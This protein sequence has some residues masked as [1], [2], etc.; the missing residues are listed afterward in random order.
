MA[1]REKEL[2]KSSANPFLRANFAPVSEENVI[3]NLAVSG[4]IPPEL[5]GR[6]L[7]IGPNPTS[8]PNPKNHHWFLGSGM[9]HGLRLNQGRAEW[10]RNNY[11][12]SGNVAQDL[13][14]KPLPKI[15]KRRGGSVNT[16]V[17][18][19]AGELYALVEAG[20]LPIRLDRDLQSVAN[21][22]FSG[23]LK[24][25]FS[26]H[27]RRDP[28]TG[29]LHVL[30][31]E[32]G[33]KSID[34][35]IVDPIG[36]S[37]TVAEIVAPHMPMIHDTAITPSFVVVLDLPFTFDIATALSGSL[38]YAWNR[39]MHGRIGLLPR[40]GDASSI[41]WF[42]SP[43]CYVYH[44]LNAYEDGD[45]VVVDVI[46]NSTSFDA[47]ISKR[48][49][50][51][52]MLVRW[53]LDLTSGKLIETELSERAVEF[54]RLNDKFVGQNYRYGYTAEF[55]ADLEFGSAFKHD[56]FKSETSE[57]NF[58]AGR[59]TMEPVFVARENATAEDEGWLLSY[60]FDK[61]TNKSDVVILDAQNFAG[62]PVATIHLPVRVPF[63]FHGN[64]INDI[65]LN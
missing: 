28:L 16:N 11:V 25:G 29:E 21:S 52:P 14:R 31:Y 32:P 24:G 30:T 61:N 54:P 51:P 48:S 38:P 53:S 57:H 45:K 15:G 20:D 27:P 17:L 44:I 5:N 50:K 64:W 8:K 2:L 3:T 18:N 55:T 47:S 37:R 60:V 19:I 6:F 7:R 63:G 42:E 13:K 26:A 65:E 33:K 23:S 9:V 58:G 35:L 10:Y 56:L 22:D 39:K 1:I 12:L 59:V 40:S 62:D 36:C 46:K 4:Q 34:Y 43:N 41:V 49:I